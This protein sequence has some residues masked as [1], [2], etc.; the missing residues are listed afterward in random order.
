MPRGKRKTV[1]EAGRMGKKSKSGLYSGRGN[2][3]TSS[4]ASAIDNGSTD[5]KPK[6][7][8]MKIRL[9]GSKTSGDLLFCGGTNWDLIGRASLPKA[10]AGV[11]PQGGRNLWGPHHI[12]SIGKI[13]IRSVISGPTA[14]H[15]IIITEDGKAMSWGRNDREQL[16]HGDNVRR[17]NPTLIESL[18]EH[19]IV[20]AA[21]G[22]NHT[23]CLT[24]YG[25]VFA[26]GDNR[27]GQLGIGLQSASV[28]N[29]VKVGHKGQPIVKVAC[30]A[31]FSM[32]LDCKGSLHSFGHPEYSQLGHN[33][34]GQ[35]FVTSNKLSFDCQLVPRKIQMFVE[36]NKG[37]VMPVPNVLLTDVACGTNHVIA[38]DIRKRVFTWGFGGYGRL[39]HAEPKDEKVPRNLKTFDVTGRGASSIY[40]GASFSMAVSEQGILYFWGQT[41]TTGEATM[42]PKPVQDLTGWKIRSVGCSNHSI[43]IAADD[44]VISWGPSPT[45][46]ELGY[47]DHGAKSST[48]PKEIKLLDGINIHSVACGYGHTLMI[49]RNDSDEDTNS[50]NKLPEF[51][52]KA[53]N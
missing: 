32:I 40:C 38:L 43:V 21:C 7:E 42:Y 23:L 19:N 29:P 33:N 6:E 8:R 2:G 14:C 39:G 9:E 30:G 52:V 27:Y 28:G 22:R 15:S 13:R 12:T 35:Y 5:D 51:S 36:K 17:D 20:S 26:F 49:A 41:K 34:D 10:A 44:S 3:A 4:A 53:E 1:D 18:K 25:T 11:K 45:Y 50:I 16:G 47:G 24:E 31:D 37:H 46:G 48:Q